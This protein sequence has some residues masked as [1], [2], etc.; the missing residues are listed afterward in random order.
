MPQAIQREDDDADAP[1]P[2]DGKYFNY[3]QRM[4]DSAGQTTGLVFARSN[5]HDPLPDHVRAFYRMTEDTITAARQITP[6]G[7]LGERL[8]RIYYITSDGLAGPNPDI[9]T[10]EGELTAFREGTLTQDLRTMRDL[11]TVHTARLMVLTAAICA[12]ISFLLLYNEV[13]IAPYLQ[14]NEATVLEQMPPAT[15]FS[16][17]VAF[18][19]GM[20][21]FCIG[22]V[23]TAFLASAQVSL[24]SYR[25]NPRFR[26]GPPMRL[27]FGGAVWFLT[28]SMLA[29]N[30]LIIG[31][32][33]TTLNQ[34]TT[35]RP[36]LGLI[37]GIVVALAFNQVV[38]LLQARAQAALQKQPDP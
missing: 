1:K 17:L 27:V 8:D 12:V 22:E 33:G 29:V 36:F 34:A 15:L 5:L 13:I 37:G 18:F 32:G 14:F 23:F 4:R 31:L 24:A 16:T 19:L 25:E 3:V 20:I 2:R 28:L 7:K 6:P 11:F 10:G 30:W 9:A 26:I 35:G 38:Q 21:G